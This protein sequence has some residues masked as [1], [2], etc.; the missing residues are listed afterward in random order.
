MAS[1]PIP[2]PIT[3]PAAAL[4]P[5]QHPQ[6][7]VGATSVVMSLGALETLRGLAFSTN[8]ETWPYHFL[9]LTRREAR[10]RAALEAIAKRSEDPVIQAMA[11]AGL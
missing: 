4:S 1:S 5:Q 8:P 7:A 2:D 6:P 10:H 3:A 9:E 11:E